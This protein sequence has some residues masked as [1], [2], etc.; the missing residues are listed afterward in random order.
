VRRPNFVEWSRHA[1]VKA[2]LEAWTPTDVERVV[3]EGHERRERNPG[4]ADWLLRAGRLVVAYNWP[5]GGDE[6]RV[7]IVSVWRLPR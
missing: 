7:R 3:I 2:Q 5:S 4:D 1:R 6:L